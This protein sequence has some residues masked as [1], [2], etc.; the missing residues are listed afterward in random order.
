MIVNDYLKVGESLILLFW[1][2]HPSLINIKENK[3]ISKNGKLI[4][5]IETISKNIRYI[6]RKIFF[7]VIMV[8][9]KF[10]ELSFSNQK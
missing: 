3:L 2:F 9:K 10:L 7:P 8:L 4:L 6:G 1:Y 5:N